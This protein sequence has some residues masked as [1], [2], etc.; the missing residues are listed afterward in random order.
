VVNVLIIS[1]YRLI[2]GSLSQIIDNA[3][4][5]SVI[6]VTEVYDEMPDVVKNQ[7]VDVVLF[8]ACP[9]DANHFNLVREFQKNHPQ[10]KVLVLCTKADEPLPSLFL[11]AGA[12]GFITRQ[13][14]EE[15]IINALQTIARGKRYISADC[16]QEMALGKMSDSDSAFAS[17]SGREMQVMMMITSGCKV[18]SISDK[19]CLSPKTINTYRY[20]LFTKLGVDSDVSLTRLAIRQGLMDA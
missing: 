6:G 14:S 11:Q 17:L 12:A 7:Q 3:S 13:S 18:M 8:E 15:E 2:C 10:I 4:D 16:A 1:S 9:P 5:F 19:L 20:R